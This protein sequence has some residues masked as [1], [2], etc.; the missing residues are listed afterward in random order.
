[1]TRSSRRRRDAFTL[2]EMLVVVVIIGILLSLITVAVNQGLKVARRA[3]NRTEIEQFKTGFEAF[4]KT[5]SVDWIPSRIVLCE[6]LANYTA[7][8][9]ASNPLYQDSYQYLGKLWPRLFGSSTVTVDWNN[10]GSVDADQILEG[11]Q[12]LVFFLGGIPSLGGTVPSTAGGIPTCLGFSSDPAN[13]ANFGPGVQVKQSS[14]EFDSSRLVYKAS[15]SANIH[16]AAPLYF[17]Y[18]DKYGTANAGQITAG[19]PYA[20]FSAYQSKNNYN[21]YTTSD[22]TTLGVWPYAQSAGQYQSPTGFQII[23]AGA[24]FLFGQGS[25]SGT[26][27]FWTPATAA[28][29]TALNAASGPA[30]ATPPG[31]DDQASFYDYALGT[32]NQ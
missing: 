14:Y 29:S 18:L 23:S 16:S 13:P 5:Y 30:T 12:C 28:N 9:N 4:K 15:P 21:R 17:S 32:S 7:P 8:A 1:M 19:R 31:A 24:D 10:N 22:C 26:S 25:T 27:N 2:I 6:T 3:V 11:D 20:Y